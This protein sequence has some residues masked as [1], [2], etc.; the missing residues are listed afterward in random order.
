MPIIVE[1]DAALGTSA[2]RVRSAVA[3]PSNGKTK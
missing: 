2:L 1:R 3:I